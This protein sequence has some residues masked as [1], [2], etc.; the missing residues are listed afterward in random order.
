M[1]AVKK[2]V[3]G[4]D[5]YTVWYAEKLYKKPGI[6]QYREAKIKIGNKASEFITILSDLMETEEEIVSKFSKNCKYEVN[7]AQREGVEVIC[8]LSHEITEVDIEEFCNFFEEFWASKDRITDKQTYQEEVKQYINTGNFAM[9]KALVNGKTIVYHTY[10]KDEQTARLLHSASLYRVDETISKN[11]VGMANRYLHKEDMM[12]FKK[13]GLSV[14]D[15]GGAGEGED[16]KNI[17]KFKESFG[18]KKVI[19]YDSHVHNGL[20]AKLLTAASRIKNVR[21]QT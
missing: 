6:I 16:V 15:W 18:G 21:K 19:Y 8:K 13:Q 10:V 1:F 4:L 14:Y 12:L 3:H 9:S 17:T 2:K 5:M 7:R 11:L 20:K